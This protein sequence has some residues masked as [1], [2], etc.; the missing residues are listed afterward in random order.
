[1]V[2]EEKL[3]DNIEAY[4]IYL[5]IKELRQSTFFIVNSQRQLRINLLEELIDLDP[6]F[7]E[8]YALLS[9]EHSEMVH[10]GLD[11]SHNRK[12]MAL[13]N[14]EKAFRLKPE[15]PEVRFAY[16]YYYYGCFKDYLRALE[17]YQYALT[18]EPGNA[19]YIAYIGFVHRRL[20]NGDE[21]IK[22]LEKAFIL[23]PN[24]MN[25][26]GELQETL[27]FFKKY[28]KINLIE[29][30]REHYR[31]AP[32]DGWLYT[33][34]ALVT[35]WMEENTTNARIIINESSKLTPDFDYYQYILWKFDIYDENY[36]NYLDYVYS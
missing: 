14:I 29:S 24:D 32:N 15:S 33:S 19:N 17:H 7:A 21:T 10:F 31:L 22:Y 16:G 26:L 30:D 18:K 20:G 11:M 5:K 27:L 28:E 6:T 2:I 25:L 4:E 8:A 1:M 36:E 23:D 9:I 13:E 35:F 3:T 34:R 12:D